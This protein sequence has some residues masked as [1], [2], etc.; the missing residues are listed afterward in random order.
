MDIKVSLN[1]REA[2]EFD[3]FLRGIIKQGND[4]KPVFVNAI[5]VLSRSTISRFR[6]AGQSPF[7][8]PPLA[9]STLRARQ[10]EGTGSAILQRYGTLMQSYLPGA[11]YSVNKISR[12]SA[13][14]GT[15]L[16]K[17]IPLQFGSK[18][19]KLPPRPQLYFTKDDVDRIMSFAATY[20][21]QPDIASK[22]RV[23]DLSDIPDS[24]FKGFD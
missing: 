9:L 20:F 1:K 8:W 14:Y 6:T 22:L 10:R 3:G 24:L 21:F 12:K 2:K 5:S 13:E 11:K 19:N 18:K 23:A 7:K 17:A 4:P 15:S 16:F